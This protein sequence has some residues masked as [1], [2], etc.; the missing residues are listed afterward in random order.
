M[1]AGEMMGAVVSASR[2]LFIL[3]ALLG[4][5][6]SPAQ[7]RTGSR[8]GFSL[9]PGQAKIVL[10]RPSIKVG[11]Q[12]TGGMFE[13]NADW[14]DQ[15]RTNLSRAIGEIQN[16]LGDRLVAYVG[17]VGEDAERVAE[18]G[19]LFTT[20]ARSV[21]EFQFFPGNRLPTKKRKDSFEWSM[22][23]EVSGLPGLDGADYA[24]FITTEDHFG[25]AGRKALQIVA[26]MAGVGVPSGVHLGYAGL[27]DLR[28]GDLVWL[29]ADPQM[30]GDPRT[31]EGARKR[32]I[33]LFEHFPVRPGPAEP[34]Y[35]VNP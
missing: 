7:E 34:T 30:G 12:S 11:A 8:P 13:P 29:N 16:K 27:V 14:T 28:T 18:Y 4:A 31:G 19:A 17:P 26:A 6:G 32:V 21:I 35:G 22:G 25:S 20:L 33:Q 9:T 2:M 23:P 15:A 1:F 3:F 5:D 10:M 24:L